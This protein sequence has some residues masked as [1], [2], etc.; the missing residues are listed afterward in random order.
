MSHKQL[1]EEQ[2]AEYQEAFA[3]FDKDGDGSITPK[4]LGAVLKAAGQNP[5]DEELQDMV[6]ELDADGNG[7]IDFS[8]FLTLMHKHSP[9]DNEE[10]ELRDAFKIFDKDGNGY[11][12]KKELREAMANLGEKLTDAE[13]DAMIREADS[14]DDGHIDF[15]E[16]VKL[17]RGDTTAAA[18]TAPVQ[19]A[20]PGKPVAVQPVVVGKPVAVQPVVVGK[21]VAGKPVAAQ[22]AVV[23][24]P[25]AGKPVA[26]QPAVVGKPAAVEERETANFVPISSDKHAA[27]AA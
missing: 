3:L 14:D 4:E 11:I 25:V 20:V 17:M 19:P 13:I 21:P 26:A 15:G 23:G 10:D 1:T 22:P 8:E 27:H 9:E 24:K 7:R 16:F 2:T 5:S 6:N 12:N 18:P